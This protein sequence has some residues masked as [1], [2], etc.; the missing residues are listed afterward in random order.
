MP[1]FND[2]L[3][4]YQKQLQMPNHDMFLI[5]LVVKTYSS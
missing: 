5:E 1:E 2:S 4:K 3:G